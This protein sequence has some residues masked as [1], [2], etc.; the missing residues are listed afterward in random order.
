M[1][2]LKNRAVAWCLSILI[3]AGA[4]L[5]L[6]GWKLHGQREQA[7]QAF[8]TGQKGFSPYN[9][10]MSRRDSAYNLLTLAQKGMDQNN[11]AVKQVQIA[12]NSLDRAE[13]PKEY[14][15][16]NSQLQGA[17]D[18][19]YQQLEPTLLESDRQIARRQYKDFCGRMSNLQ[20]DDYYNGLAEEY[21]RV[22][23]GFPASVIGALTGA[24]KLPVFR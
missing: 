8:F 15:E 23:S 16:A 6:G 11:E 10:L 3:A 13:T 18:I 4:T 9:D 24:G 14:Y 19:L 5:G 7:E 20:Y 12:W 21:N 1:S 17:V 2:L 22:C